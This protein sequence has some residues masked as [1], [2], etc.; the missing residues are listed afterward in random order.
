M[1]LEFRRSWGDEEV[2]RFR[3]SWVRFVESE[4]QPHD[5]EAR[6]RGHVGLELWERAGELGFLCVDIPEQWGGAGQRGERS[7][8]SPLPTRLVAMV[9]GC[10]L[11]S[12]PAERSNV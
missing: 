12:R 2:E 1:P 4:M 3:D 8:V 11:S 6:R 10:S 7:S 5:A 9:F